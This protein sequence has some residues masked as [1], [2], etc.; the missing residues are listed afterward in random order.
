MKNKS[1]YIYGG[2]VVVIVLLIFLFNYSNEP[3]PDDI[4]IAPDTAIP[5]DDVHKGLG[6]DM[7]SSDPV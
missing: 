5:D 1:L 7:P 6:K 4:A 2:L 3:S